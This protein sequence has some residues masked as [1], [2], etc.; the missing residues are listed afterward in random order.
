MVTVLQEPMRLYDF[1]W[2]ERFSSRASRHGVLCYFDSGEADDGPPLVMLHALGI[3]F[4][5]WRHV[6][7]ILAPQQR[8]IGI[9]M[10]G[11]GHSAKPRHRWQLSDMTEA[12]IGLLDELG[13]ER[14][15]IAGHSFG[16]RIALE[17]AL[18]HP[19][20]VAGLLLLNA[21]GFIRYPKLLS[22][23]GERLLKPKLVA[24]I[25]VAL[26]KPILG[27]IV[28]HPTS[29]SG[30][31]AASVTERFRPEFA[32]D[33]AYHACP[34]LPALLSDVIDELQHLHLP[35][36]VLWGRRDRL[37]RYR[38]VEKHLYR[39]PTARIDVIDDCGHMPNFEHPDRVAKAAERLRSRVRKG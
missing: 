3:N 29:P 1:A 33:F 34:L 19:E 38:S 27:T 22:H 24:P 15:M 31:F 13:I 28:A 30:E 32:W 16:G 23:V 2:P 7:Q 4:T 12:V 36:E 25:M 20:R 10:P 8:L 18:R 39:I 6:A 21:A 37:L 17:L 14:A 26:S 5:Q 9:D 11:C 35:I